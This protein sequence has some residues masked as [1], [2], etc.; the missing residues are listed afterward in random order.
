MGAFEF[1]DASVKMP[2]TSEEFIEKLL[3][4]LRSGE[5]VLKIPSREKGDMISK[6]MHFHLEPEMFIQISGYTDFTFP[7]GHFKLMPGEICLVPPKVGHSE[8]AFPCS[9]FPFYNL[10]VMMRGANTFMHIANS[11]KNRPHTLK[12][13]SYETAVN[14][15]RLIRY[16]EDVC[17]LSD[18]RD[19][20]AQ[21][22][23]TASI[24]Q[25]ILYLLLDIIR[26]KEKIDEGGRASMC[27]TIVAGS[28]GD[29]TMNV[30]KIAGIL[31]CSPD[32][33]SHR[34]HVETG[35]KLTE[36]INQQRT[37]MAKGLLESSLLNIKEIAWACGY[38]D[39]GYLTRVFRRTQGV[40]P[41]AYRKKIS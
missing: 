19:G 1:T 7:S 2:D 36:Y 16:M 6:G 40:S 24:L 23:L 9:G 29:P 10:V 13:G 28:I 5:D 3:L 15:S 33:L 21:S 27:R 41:R 11:A 39:P 38:T 18:A 32:Y 25:A 8:K 31:K 37:E 20:T 26:N 14:T 34:F 17:D 4:K 30:R 35:M 22:E 12:G